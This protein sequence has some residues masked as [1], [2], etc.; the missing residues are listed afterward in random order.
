MQVKIYVGNEKCTKCGRSHKKVF[1]I[2]GKPYGS[3]CANELLGKNLDAPLW[4]YV[5]AEEWVK[6]EVLEVDYKNVEDCTVN[7]I[8]HYGSSLD[9]RDGSSKVW[10]KAIKID[11]KSVKVEWQYE[12]NDY[13][14][15]R[16][17]ELK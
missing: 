15:K 13:I 3:S 11:G 2:D 17:N 5:L 14:V 9:D 8:N 16:Y 6:E 10:E 7:F 12:I 1:E 4:L